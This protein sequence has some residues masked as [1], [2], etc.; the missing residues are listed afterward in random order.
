MTTLDATGEMQRAIAEWIGPKLATEISHFIR[1]QVLDKVENQSYKMEF[2][3]R[4]YNGGLVFVMRAIV[5][6]EERTNFVYPG[7]ANR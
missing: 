1:R 2:E 5:D 6:G 7:D 4:N 3:I